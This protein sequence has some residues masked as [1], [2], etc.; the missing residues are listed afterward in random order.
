[1]SGKR[2]VDVE[3]KDARQSVAVPE[4]EAIVLVI[5]AYKEELKMIKRKSTC[6]FQQLPNATLANS[7][8]PMNEQELRQNN[9]VEA[10]SA[11]A[12]LF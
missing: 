6:L 11:P 2:V 10:S 5:K 4:G 7:S 1:M 12:T 9:S 3:V 8:A